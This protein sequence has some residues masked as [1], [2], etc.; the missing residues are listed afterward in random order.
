MGR[1]FLV[2]IG[3]SLLQVLQ[4]VNSAADAARRC[5]LVNSVPGVFNDSAKPKE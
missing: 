4:N 1:Y 2:S 3:A 5:W